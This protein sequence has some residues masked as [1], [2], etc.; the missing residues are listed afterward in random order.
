MSSIGTQWTVLPLLI[1]EAE[2]THICGAGDD[3]HELVHLHERNLDH[4]THLS[5]AT[6]ISEDVNGYLKL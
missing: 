5:V 6:T 2:G 1:T 4:C 3:L